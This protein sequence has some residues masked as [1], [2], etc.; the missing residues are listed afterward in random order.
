MQLSI[1]VPAFNEERWLPLLLASIRQQSFRDF[2]VIVADAR[3]TDKTRAIARDFGARIVEGGLPGPGRNRG[4]EQAQGDVLAFFDAD[5]VLSDPNFLGDS[6]RE[7]KARSLDLATCRARAHEGSLIDQVMHGAYNFYS[8][9]TERMLP[10]APGF[11]FFIRREVHTFLHGFDEEV[12]M[13]EDMEYARRAVRE[14][15]HF[16]ILREH[17]IY[18][19]VRRLEKEGR[20][21]LT[22]KYVY[23]ELAM[24]TRGPFKTMPF[25]YD[26]GHTDKTTNQAPRGRQ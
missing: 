18:V 14:G 7:M 17:P 5:V 6:L 23:G 20:L 11:C 26:F 16:G 2:E 3:S 21:M 4:A 8:V 24:L 9:A 25:R 10:H 1:I 13:A 15:F 22:T 19:S 12:V